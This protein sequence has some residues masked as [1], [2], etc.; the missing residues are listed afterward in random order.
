VILEIGYYYNITCYAL[1]PLV[2]SYEAGGAKQAFWVEG[3]CGVGLCLVPRGL[4]QQGGL[5]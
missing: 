4:P 2:L 3:D 5:F 1:I